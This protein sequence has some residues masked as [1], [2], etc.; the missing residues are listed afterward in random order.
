VTRD[1]H[2]GIGFGPL[3][4]L[5][6]GLGEFSMQVGR[7]LAAR[8]PQ[9]RAER[10]VHLHFHLRPEQHGLFGDEVGYLSLRPLDRVVHLGTRR[11]DVW[12]TLNQHVAHRPPL[13]TRHR[14]LTVHDLNF[15]YAKHGLSLARHALVA[16]RRLAR[17][18]RVVAITQHVAGDVR[19][20]AGYR[21]RIDVVYNGARS[22]VGEP[23][24][25]VPGLH[26]GG[27]LFHLSRMAPSKNVGALLDLAAAWPEQAVVLAGPTSDPVLRVRA[28]VAARGLENVRVLDG[29]DEAQKAWLYASCAGFLFPSLTEGF[30]LP[31]IEAMHFGVP[32]FLSDRTS[33]PEVGGEAAYYLR[34][35]GPAAMR[36]VIES[37][38]A[39]AARP[40]R[41]DEFRR[42]AAR[43]SWDDCAARYLAIYLEL[44]EVP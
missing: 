17:A 3:R 7:R 38:L 9:L 2:I 5:Q 27:F 36:G 42:R 34:D 15:L 19:D 28:E 30:G 41:R 13:G 21:G 16:R 43:F 44:A 23:Q 40:G 4:T 18:D 6:D 31:P 22:L 1:L 14:L 33:L 11:F 37:G 20:R 12:H 25:P 8:A 10:R 32:V 26:P 35:F 29:I 24:R 39:D